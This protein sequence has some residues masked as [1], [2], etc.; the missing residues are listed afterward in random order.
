MTEES[1]AEPPDYRAASYTK[2]GIE[3]RTGKSM[4]KDK[5]ETQLRMNNLCTACDSMK[6]IVL[7][8]GRGSNTELNCYKSDLKLAQGFTDFYVRFDVHNFN[9]KHTELKSCL[10][11]APPY[12]RS[13]NVHTVINCF[14]GCSLRKNPGPDNVAICLL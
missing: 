2:L 10:L 3:I 14:K 7:K 1:A 9:D 6:C 11:S 13:F 5:I 4:Y 12:N 8:E